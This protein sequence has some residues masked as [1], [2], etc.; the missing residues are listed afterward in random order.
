MRFPL[1]AAPDPGEG[2]YSD[3]PN[4]FAYLRGLLLR[5]EG[6]EGEWEESWEGM[7]REREGEGK[8]RGKGRGQ[9]LQIFWPRTAPECIIRF[10]VFCATVCVCTARTL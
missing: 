9:A 6:E 4:L 7:G 2:A 10:T 3:P 1:G 5:G 8:R